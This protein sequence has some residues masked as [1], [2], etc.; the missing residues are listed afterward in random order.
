[1]NQ[2]R[3]TSNAHHTLQ[4]R[5]QVKNDLS[6]QLSHTHQYSY[7]LTN[8][9]DQSRYYPALSSKL[10]IFDNSRTVSPLNYFGRRFIEPNDMTQHYS[11]AGMNMENSRRIT[12]IA[13]T[14]PQK[15]FYPQ[16]L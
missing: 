2:P 3:V 4:H 16:N 10:N 15:L 5:L 6:E 1:M 7:A 14:K 9:R 13:F 11:P 8:A 12:G